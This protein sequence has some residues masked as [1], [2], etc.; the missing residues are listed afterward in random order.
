MFIAKADN[1][2]SELEI[3]S[4]SWYCTVTVKINY[5]NEYQFNGFT[6][7]KDRIMQLER[8]IFS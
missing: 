3:Y 5:H 6:K 4:K 7:F 1:R 8:P 2:L